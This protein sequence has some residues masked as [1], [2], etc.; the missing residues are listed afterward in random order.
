MSD[1]PRT[2]A[3]WR[4]NVHNHMGIGDYPDCIIHPEDDIISDLAA[5][6][7]ECVLWSES[8][9]QWQSR[10]EQA[11]RERDSWMRVA[12]RCEEEHRKA[13]ASVKALTAD[14][15]EARGANA[16]VVAERNVFRDANEKL[17]E[18]NADL[19]AYYEHRECIRCLLTKQWLALT[20]RLEARRAKEVAS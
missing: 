18:A 15:D 14:R 11:E 7:R 6:E 20:A 8:A 12:R 4:E 3:E 2:S 17:T 19:M 9:V 1:T 10:A 13:E 5:A 16:V